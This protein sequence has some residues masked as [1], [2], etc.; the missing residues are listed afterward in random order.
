MKLYL[1][2]AGVGSLDYLTNYAKNIIVKADLVITSERLF[3]AQSSLNSKMIFLEL[4]AIEECLI[5]QKEKQIVAVLVSG[6]VGFFSIAK[7]LSKK[8][9]DVELV[10]GLSSL[11]YFAAKLQVSYENL[12]TISLHGRDKSIIP[13]VAYH[14]RI[15][16]LTGGKQKAGAVL[17]Q[18][19]S[20]GLGQ[21]QIAA[22]EY[23]SH[24]RERIL[25]GMAADLQQEGFADLT[26][27]YI[28][29]KRAV[30]PQD[31]LKDGDFLRAGVPMTKEEVRAV[32][33]D[34]LQLK[35]TDIV[36][37]IGCGTGAMAI[38]MARKVYQGEV[39]G[40]ENN[41]EAVELS[42]KN[43]RQLGA[44][45]LQIIA[46]TA[47]E[48]MENLPKVDKAF[49]GGS[50]GRLEAIIALLLKKNPEVRIVINAITLETLQQTISCLEAQQLQTEVVCMNIAKA[51]RVGGYHM[52]K[53]ENPIY[54]I[55]GEYNENNNS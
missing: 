12:P 35:P 39:Y 47:P 14:Q 1:V 55:T 34:K 8:F 26:V 38:A 10:N 24:P 4:S 53:A 18:L 37:D 32:S 28:E 49:I 45:N 51:E 52:L 41:P 7:K 40:I 46:G 44:Y 15:F 9:A 22:G 29:N 5:K 25:R 20:A 2:G 50:Q 19:T 36:C 42:K 33:M 11:Q 17:Q 31:K 48:A 54:I 6:D 27:L 3:E 23:L 16:V 21:V 43:R 13:Y 30:N